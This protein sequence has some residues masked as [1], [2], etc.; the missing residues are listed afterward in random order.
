M[1]TESV[2]ENKKPS[3]KKT[4]KKVNIKGILSVI[5]CLILIPACILVMW[6]VGGRSFYIGSVVIIVLAMIPFFITFEG[7]KPDA[8]ELVVI[9]VLSAIAAVSR[10]AF[11][12]IPHFKPI[13]AV[14]II[15]GISF[16]PQAGFLTGA[17]SAVAS[18]F[19]FGMG[20]WTPW[21]MFS[22]GMAGFI[23]GLLAKVGIMTGKN[24]I[25]D[26][27]IGFIIVVLIVGPILDT[28]SVFSMASEINLG[29]FATYF[30]SGFPVNVILATCTFLTILLFSKP[31]TE[32]LDRIKLKYGMLEEFED[33]V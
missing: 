20:P 18:D 24:G 4:G 10:V 6:K 30:A 19:V 13:I 9:A 22:F 32:K 33:E 17:I 23:A 25:K 15:T 7:R 27:I 26:G 5:C 11:I 8:R 28:S 21:Q 16:G 12:M 31:M 29:A 14:I 1:S 3:Q 2:T